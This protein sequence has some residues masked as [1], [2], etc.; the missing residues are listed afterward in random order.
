MRKICFVIQRYGY[1]VNG[2]AELHCLQLAEKM[3]AMYQVD[4]LT[5]K[6]ID[7]MTWK[8]EYTDDLEKVNGVTVHRFSVV[9]ER[10]QEEFDKVNALAVTGQ[11]PQEREQEWLEKQG[12][13]VPGLIDYIREHKDDY[14]CFLF[15]A[16]LYYPTV[17][18]VAE[19]K[20][21]AIVLSL[22]HDEPFLGM[23]L[24]RDMFRMPRA[25]FFNTDEER[26]LVRK[27]FHNHAIPYLLGGVG[28]DVPD[29]IDPG[30]FTS[31]YHLKDY[32]VYVGRIDEGK[33][34][35][36]LFRYFLDYKK[37][38]PGTLKLVLMGKP[39][40]SIPESEDIVS[41][42]FVNDQDKFDGIAGAKLLVLPSIFESLSMVVLEAFSLRI[43]VLVN[44]KCEVLKAHCEKSRGGFFY[45]NQFG[46]ETKLLALLGNDDLRDRMG[47]DGYSYVK[48][49]YQWSVICRKLQ[50]L[51]E[52]VCASSDVN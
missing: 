26:K 32:I 35:G 8:D 37:K 19:V 36:E 18:G 17:R 40:I 1:E 2:G 20:E 3:C 39:V 51:I 31:K 24:Y 15:M 43:P 27:K 6:A 13:L 45:A 21:K 33:N 29:D 38:Y 16:Y 34:C 44:G 47:E 28:V 9:K 42:G 7:Y 52:Y 41:L 49:N 46:Y 5:T 4:V 10:I 30:R 50:W 25:F 14:D 22:A 11:L 48:A 12:P 23:K